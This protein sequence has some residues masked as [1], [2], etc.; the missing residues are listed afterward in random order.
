MALTLLVT[1]V[2]GF[3]GSSAAERF[4]KEKYTMIGIDN[5]EQ[6]YPQQIKESNL[7]IL[8]EYDNFRFVEGDFADECFIESLFDKYRITNIIHLGAKTGVR[9]SISNPIEYIKANLIGTT[10]LLEQCKKHKIQEFIFAS[11][12]SVYGN[13]LDIPFK[14]GELIDK[15]ISPYAASKIMA[16]SITYT[17]HKLYDIKMTILRFFTVYGPRGRP[18]MAPYIFMNCI[19]GSKPIIQ[20]GDGDTAR[21]YT[22]IS[23]IVD[24]IFEALKR[25]SNWQY[26]IINLGNS[27]PVRLRDFIKEIES[28]VGKEAEIIVEDPKEGDV[29]ITCADISKARRLLDYNPKIPLKKGLEQMFDWYNS[30]EEKYDV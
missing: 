25:T 27:Y 16:E 23:D 10:N 20:Y 8:S 14:E 13:R 6:N 18:D 5:F 15:P 29:S 1:G 22:F 21:D 24:G 11:S 19:V 9:K 26:E 4:L 2:A 7:A 17:Y 28:V 12:S 30:L 3:I